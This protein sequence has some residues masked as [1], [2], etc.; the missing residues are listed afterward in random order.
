MPLEG[1]AVVITDVGHIYGTISDLGVR[2]A[3]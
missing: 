1:R 3:G 2:E